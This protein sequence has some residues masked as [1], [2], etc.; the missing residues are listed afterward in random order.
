[1]KTTILVMAS[2]IVL[3]GATFG[4][5]EGTQPMIRANIPFQ[6]I[7]GTKMLP[8]GEYDFTPNALGDAVRVINIKGGPSSDALVLTRLGGEIHASPQ[9]SHLV[10]DKVGSTY[11]FSELWLP[12]N[13][14]F[15][16]NITKEKHEHRTIKVPNAST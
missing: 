12:G 11:T 5:A 7:V 6:F 9:D 8:A 2:V 15:L 4:L 14:G 13:D 16:L 1:V 10:F 3:L